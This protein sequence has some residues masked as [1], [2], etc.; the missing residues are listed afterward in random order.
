[1]QDKK[2]LIERS[3]IKWAFLLRGPKD[4]L[5]CL[6]KKTPWWAFNDHHNEWEVYLPDEQDC[7]PENQF[8]LILETISKM[9]GLAAIRGFSAALDIENFVIYNNSGERSVT[10]HLGQLIRNT[11]LGGFVFENTQYIE[12]D[13]SQFTPE[14]LISL[15]DL[16]DYW[17]QPDA[18]HYTGLYRIHEWIQSKAPEIIKAIGKSE[19]DRF[20]HTCCHPSSGK[21]ARHAKTTNDA[22]KKPMSLWEARGLVRRI[23]NEYIKSIQP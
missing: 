19:N 3:I 6:P 4:S 2:E 13:F 8:K 23:T 17:A 12:I 1:M 15:T 22:P 11:D 10:T 16:I 21:R 7:L 18:E 9:N 14:Q 20:T 5:R